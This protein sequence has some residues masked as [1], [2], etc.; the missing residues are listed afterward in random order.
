VT[1][2]QLARSLWVAVVDCVQDFAVLVNRQLSV[3]P[4]VNCGIHDPLHLAADGFDRPQQELVS[5]QLC[6][7]DVKGRVCRNEMNV[8]FP[9][10]N[11]VFRVGQFLQT[12]HQFGIRTLCRGQLRAR[13]FHRR[14]ELVQLSQ[15]LYRYLGDEVTTIGDHT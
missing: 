15:I 11:L 10:V 4:D 8:A 14:P 13:T 1:I 12:L 6:D 9:V 7:A 3:V 2:H 5:R